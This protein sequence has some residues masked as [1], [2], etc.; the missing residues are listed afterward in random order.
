MLVHVGSTRTIE[1]H[2][3]NP[4]DWI[5]H[6]HMTHHTMNQMG[7]SIPNMVGVKP[8]ALDDK[9]RRL[10]PDYMTMGQRGMGNMADMRMA[11]PENSIP[12]LGV[13]GQYG[14]TVIGSMFTMLKVRERTNGYDDP[15]WYQ[16]PQGTVSYPAPPEQ[17]RR[18]GIEPGVAEKRVPASGHDMS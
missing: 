1:L 5:M 7:H 17:L 15:G 6:C 14:N 2:A 3:D 8:G 16:H 9:V 11:V 10:L 18:D 12:M 4:G 13:K